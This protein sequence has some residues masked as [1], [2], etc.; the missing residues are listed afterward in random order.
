M[1]DRLTT[2]DALVFIALSQQ[3]L[4]GIYW[5]IWEPVMMSGVK[6]FQY[7]LD[8]IEHRTGQAALPHPALGQDLTPFMDRGSEP[9]SMPASD[10]APSAAAALT[11]SSGS[12]MK[13]PAPF[14]LTQACTDLELIQS[15]LLAPSSFRLDD[16]RKTKRNGTS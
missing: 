6:A 3:D 16:T 8:G 2:K 10:A 15:R 9:R 13:G 14:M 5:M 12:W 7:L 1:R 11:L 4:A